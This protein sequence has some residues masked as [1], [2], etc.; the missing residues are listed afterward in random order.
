MKYLL[1]IVCFLLLISCKEKSEELPKTEI[2]NIQDLGTLATT[3]YTFGKI[4]YLNDSKDWYRFG[5]RKILISVKA[6]VKAGVDLTKVNKDDIVIS[7]D[8]TKI[9]LK[10]PAPEIVS[11]DMNPNDIK[12]EMK[13]V[14]GFRFEFT[15]QEKVKILQLG[16]ENIKREMLQS[17]ILN[18]AK[19]NTRIF[20]IDFYKD[21]GYQE[22]DVEFNTLK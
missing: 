8:N 1:Q 7:E 14:N 4:I 10:L 2:Y 17:S 20:L 11:F 12:T 19:K 5:D 3:E 13:D 6:K 16:E 21:M 9:S 18:D 22:V 15:Q